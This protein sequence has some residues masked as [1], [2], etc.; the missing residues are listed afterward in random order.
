MCTSGRKGKSAP[1]LH[2]MRG[3]RHE[4]W[5]GTVPLCSALMRLHL[6]HCIQAW[7]IQHRKDVG[8]HLEKGHEDAQKAG[9][10]LF[11]RKAEGAEG[12]QPGEGKGPGRPH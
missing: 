7:S 11:L 9:A 12:V 6:E 5:E 8:G 1:R 4:E 2:Q 3:G 10:P